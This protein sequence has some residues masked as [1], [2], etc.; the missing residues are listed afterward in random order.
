MMNIAYFECFSGISGDMILGSLL[1]LG[2]DLDFLTD[3]LNKINLSGYH[4]SSKE[5]KRCGI[6]GTKFDVIVDAENNKNIKHR[7]LHDICGIINGSSLDEHIKKTSV[8][9]FQRLAKAEANVHGVGEEEVH[10]H[11]VG[12]I[13]SIVDIVGTVIGF[14]KLGFKSILFSQI[15]TGTGYINCEHGALPIPA[16][17]TAELL[18]GYTLSGTDIKKELT[19]P[20]GASIITTTGKQTDTFPEFRIKNIGYGA[21]AN[22]NPLLPNLLRVFVGE[23]ELSIDHSETNYLK[24]EVWIVET[25]ID[26]MTG[27]FFGH[28]IDKLLNAGAVDAYMTSIQMKKA[29]PSVL[30]S[31]IVSEKRL[32][33]VESVFFDHTTTFGVRKYKVFRDKLNREVVNINTIYGN[34]K[35]K[36]GTSNKNIKNIA[37]EYDDCKRIADLK[38]LPLKRVYNEV[39]KSALDSKLEVTDAK[40]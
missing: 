10:F 23:T 2:L 17:A 21:G 9:I 4:L 33:D 7:N 34:V 26:D 35:V 37:P 24:D 15:V 25:N 30:I 20:T 38:G 8:S 5:V 13:D 28:I 14:H 36:I 6:R 1:D 40:K 39:I 12:S 3:E 22:D 19:T 18:R 31:A 27:E 16:P 32:A 11:E 29:R